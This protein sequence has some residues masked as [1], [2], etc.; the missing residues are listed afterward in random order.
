MGFF[1]D[2][3]GPAASIAGGIFGGPAGAA[4]GGA[5]GGA[6]SGKSNSQAA[7]QGTTTTQ[8]IDPRFA[9]MLFGANGDNGLLSQFQG[10]LNQPQSAALNT[11]GNTANNYLGNYSG[12]DMDAARNSAYRLM[13]DNQAPTAG[14]GLQVQAYGPASIA[15]VGETQI[16]APSQNSLDLRS[17]Y[18]RVINGDAG[19]NPYL[20]RSIQ[21]GIDA[22]NAGFNTNQAN[23]TNALQRQV[24]PGIRANAIASGGFGGSRQGIAEGLALSDYTNQLTN[25]NTQLGTANSANAIGAQANAFNQGQDRSLNALNT[26]SGQQYATA[27][28]NA[29]LRQ[30]AQLANMNANNAAS[31]FTAQQFN[32]ASSQNASMVNSNNQ[33][34]A[35]LALQTNAQNNA[36]RL[37]GAGLLSGQLGNAVQ[38]ATNMQNFGINRAGQV[39][40]LLSPFIGV[41]GSTTTTQPYYNN[42]A[43]NVIGGAL[44]SLSLFNQF[45]QANNGYNAQDLRNTVESPVSNFRVGGGNTGF[46]G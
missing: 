38:G 46:W 1:K 18:D 6:L 15:Q 23:V 31:L 45:N 7:A 21:A 22:T 11:Y 14:L 16:Q 32:N 19:A 44:G 3:L 17:A 26:L 40:G 36:S 2:L 39:A 41:N 5:L 8:Q 25:A 28:Q 37:A 42:T 34:N 30:R 29:E 24:L 9:N 20:T 13:Q 12:A 33:L 10:Y 27:A 4:I 43:N 35:N